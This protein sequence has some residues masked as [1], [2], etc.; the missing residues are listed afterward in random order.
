MHEIAH[1]LVR[2]GHGHDAVWKAKALSIGCDGQRCGHSFTST[3]R[4]YE[5]RC[6]ASHGFHLSPQTRV[7]ELRSQRRSLE[8]HRRE[9]PAQ[10]KPGQLRRNSMRTQKC[11]TD[12]T[13]R[14]RVVATE[15]FKAAEAA[16]SSM[17][18]CVGIADGDASAAKSKQPETPQ[19][20]RRG[21]ALDVSF[22]SG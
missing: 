19:S 1:A 17:L 12:T 21:S 9:V 3:E 6:D 5:L 13:S 20:A 2:K 7:H 11:F 15:A 22:L 18:R 8:A 16:W 14:H 10:L 4:P